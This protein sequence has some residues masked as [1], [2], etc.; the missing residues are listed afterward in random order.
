LKLEPLI[1]AEERIS[2][3]HLVAAAEFI[4]SRQNRD[5]GF[6]SFERRRGPKWL[7]RFNPSEMFGNSMV[8]GSYL[9]C[10][11]SCLNGLA[12]FQRRFPDVLRSEI[13]LAIRRGVCAL[14]RGQRADGSWEGSWGV[15]F[16]YSIF[17]CVEGLL[18]ANL[19]VDHPAIRRAGAWLLARQKSDGGW[20][21]HWTSCGTREYREHP[22]SQVI[23]SAWATLT[24]LKMRD[25]AAQVAI[26]RAVR[27]LLS[28]QQ[29]DGDFPE[30]SPAGVFFRTG[31]LH[32]TLYKNYFTLW[33]LGRYL[34]ASS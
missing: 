22:Q 21:E 12:H 5:G 19:P 26:Q 1:P 28:R 4:L 30:E 8:E 23:M 13:A 31:L 24:L 27:W 25:G 11:A 16:T 7:E 2:K 17:F 32:Y 33:A 34:G 14:L 20:G 15:N 29:S 18:A 9:E 6:G 3:E 10:T